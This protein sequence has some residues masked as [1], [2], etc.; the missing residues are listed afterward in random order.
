M[1]KH[2]QEEVE[3]ETTT[4]E[5]EEIVDIS[6]ADF[7]ELGIFG[8]DPVWEIPLIRS[9]PNPAYVE[10]GKESKIK[11]FR[12]WVPVK[13]L[14][15]AELLRMQEGQ[16]IPKGS[17]NILDALA[18]KRW[19]K[20]E[21]D[22]FNLA[23]KRAGGKITFTKD[24]RGKANY[25]VGEISIEDLSRADIRRLEAAISPGMNKSEEDSED[26]IRAG[27]REAGTATKKSK[28]MP[29]GPGR[30]GEDP[31]TDQATV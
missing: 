19:S 9:I 18:I 6:D 21:A 5:D 2:D 17:R 27:S 4:E 30:A 24:P 31:A 1:V 11:K 28:R 14:T 23:I 22:M 8:E 10:G 7:S 16:K 25:G 15:Q 26:D 3:E 20:T 29:L 13:M 12:L